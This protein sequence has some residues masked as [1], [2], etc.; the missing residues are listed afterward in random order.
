MDMDGERLTVSGWYAAGRF[1][2]TPGRPPQRHVL[3]VIEGES[4]TDSDSSFKEGSKRVQLSVACS[5]LGQIDSS[6]R[7]TTLVAPSLIGTSGRPSVSP[8]APQIHGPAALVRIYDLVLTD[9]HSEFGPRREDLREVRGTP[10]WRIET[11]ELEPVVSVKAAIQYLSDSAMSPVARS[12]R[13]MLTDPSPS[14]AAAC[15]G[16]S[17][18][19]R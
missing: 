5:E 1:F 18:L 9:T 13:G 7:F 8:G 17:M 10:E 15:D 4:V 12:S 3:A 16:F 2:V 14:F 19:V 11:F 6:G